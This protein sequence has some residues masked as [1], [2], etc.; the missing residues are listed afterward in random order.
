MPIRRSNPWLLVL[1]I[2]ACAF[3]FTG[4]LAVGQ[5]AAGLPSAPEPQCAEV[6]AGGEQAPRLFM[7]PMAGSIHIE[8]AAS[9][10]DWAA[11]GS[12][13]GRGASRTTCS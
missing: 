3:L 9:G 12:A 5:E 8:V 11:E 13:G 6:S 4:T 7:A 1:A 2:A 10:T